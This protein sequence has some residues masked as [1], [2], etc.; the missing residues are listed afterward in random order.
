[1]HL[2]CLQSMLASIMPCD[3]GLIGVP[4]FVWVRDV[5][6]WMRN[7]AIMGGS[8]ALL[9]GVLVSV[10]GMIHSDLRARALRAWLPHGRRPPDEATRRRAGPCDAPAR[11][12]C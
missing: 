8:R 2:L 11:G 10:P 9:T 1:M 5:L 12:R 4:T 3:L 7:V 6:T